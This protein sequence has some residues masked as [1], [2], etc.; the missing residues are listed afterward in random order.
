MNLFISR[1]VPSEGS[2]RYNII[3]IFI[4]I[5]KIDNKYIFSYFLKKAFYIPNLSSPL[6]MLA[7]KLNAE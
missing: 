1:S 5:N 3:V 4:I 7:A 2:T 6:V